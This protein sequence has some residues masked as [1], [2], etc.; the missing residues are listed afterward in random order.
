[1]RAMLGGERGPFRDAVVYNAAAALLVAGRAANLRE[2]AEMAAEAI[3]A[4]RAKGDARTPGRDHQSRCAACRGTHMSVL[5]RICADKRDIVARRKR[6]HPLGEVE[7]MARTA[8]SPRGF[9]DALRRASDRAEL[10]PYRG[11]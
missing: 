9:A 2:G 11:D 10:R 5:A 1:M 7:M 6:E 4:G 3:D 8:T